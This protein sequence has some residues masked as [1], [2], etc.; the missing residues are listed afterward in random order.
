MVFF[1]GGWFWTLPRQQ[2]TDGD[3]GIFIEPNFL[4]SRVQVSC[5]FAGHYQFHGRGS[6]FPPLVLLDPCD[7]PPSALHVHLV[8]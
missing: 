3:H 1:G 6:F 7:S 2:T 4:V 8:T 5:N